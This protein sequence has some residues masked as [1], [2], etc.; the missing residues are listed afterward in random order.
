VD[1]TWLVQDCNQ[2]AA[3]VAQA[4]TTRMMPAQPPSLP[5]AD[6]DSGAHPMDA[7]SAAD[8]APD[9]SDVPSD[10]IAAQQSS[11]AGDGTHA[12]ESAPQSTAAAAPSEQP[13]GM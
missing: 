13:N 8:P 6:P 10:A 2:L 9:S 3:L 1:A 5:A 12:T 7:V 4:M 11:A